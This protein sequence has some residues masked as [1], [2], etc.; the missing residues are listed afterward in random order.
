[1]S[2]WDFWIDRGGTF[3]DVI[4]RR[5]DASLYTMK[6]LS[7]DPAHYADAATE[8]IA[9]VLDHPAHTHFSDSQILS[10]RMGTTVATNALLER[11]GEPLAL[12]ATRGFRDAWRIGYQNRPDLFTRRIIL[13]E[14]LYERVVEIDERVS[15]QGEILT[16]LNIESAIP[17]LQQIFDSGLRSIAIALM[18]G[19]RWPAHE[20]KLA[21][22]ARDIGFEQVSA[23]HEVAAV[24]KLVSRGD[25]TVVDA[26]LS[27]L[28][29]R[30]IASVREF[31]DKQS[32]R[33]QLMFMQ[34]NGGLID[35]E[36]FRG[37]NSI[38]SGPAGGVVGMVHAAKSA[39]HEK[40]IGFDMGGTSTDVS[41]FDGEYRRTD[42]TEIAGVRLRAPMMAI[43]TV[44]AGGGSVLRYLDGRFQVGPDSAGANPG[45]ACY[46]HGGP[47]CITDANLMLGRIDAEFFP[48]VFGP[49]SDQSL[50]RKTVEKKFEQLTKEIPQSIS[51]HDIAEGFLRV[52]VE[53]MANAI[54]KISIR[55]G[56][57]PQ[58]FILNC[59][60]GAGGQHACQVAD[61]LDIRQVLI[62]P[63]GG[64]LSAWGIGQADVTSIYQQ[65]ALLDLTSENIAAAEAML[66]DLE[67]QAKNELFAHGNTTRSLVVHKR[68][69]LRYPGSDTTLSVHW[70]S[71]EKM[72]A[73][74][75]QLHQQ[76]FG[77][78]QSDSLLVIDRLEAEATACEPQR[79]AQLQSIISEVSP[80]PIGTRSAWFGGQKIKA[81]WYQR[82]DL[83]PGAQ[84]DG[85]ALIAESTGT[86]VLQP[87]WSLAVA[88]DGQLELKRST[89]QRRDFATGTTADPVTLEVFNNLFMHIAEEIGVVLENTAY[90]VNIKER[91]DFSC[92]LFDTEGLLIA[93]APHM[94]VH[95]GSMGDSVRTVMSENAGS[96]RLGDVYALNAPYN[97]GT[98]LPD[99]TVVTP[100]F[101]EQSPVPVF[102]VASRAHHADIGGT[103]PGSMPPDSTHID[104]EGILFDNFLLVRDGKLREADLRRALADSQYPARNPDQNIEDLKAQIA[105]NEKG[106][107][108]LLRVVDH[109][110]FDVVTAYMQHVQDNAEA[111]VR[112]VL[113][114]LEDGHFVYPLD[115]GLQ[116]EVDIKVDRETRSARIDFSGTSAQSDDNFNAPTSVCTAAVLYVFRTLVDTNIP[117][118]AGCL[119]PLNIDIPDDCILKPRYPAAVVAGNVETSQCI[120]DALYGALGTQA[121]AQGTMNNFTFGDHEYQYYETI[122]GGSGAGPGYN[123]TDA[124]HTHMTNSRLTDPE[125]LEWRFPV[126]VKSFAIR[127]ESGGDGK[128]CGGNGVTREIEFRRPMTASILSNHRLVA[129][130]G[131]ADGDSAAC[132]INTIIKADGSEQKLAATASANVDTGDVFVISTPGGGGYGKK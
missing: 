62:H 116:I 23:S 64:V 65:T 122:C 39:G 67:T 88:A 74:F 69:H 1:M 77:F 14:M 91:L 93:N 82:D 84:I 71:A 43:H 118:N 72:A 24:M 6:L 21:T 78:T 5:P 70:D 121:A 56:Y 123:G 97:G 107:N 26:Y 87:G 52:A 22:I 108:E 131:M 99:V 114:Q 45:P 98:H 129:P 90:S 53:K 101:I 57:D 112:D 19:Y 58:E 16:A 46:G 120:V 12:V 55:R 17:V 132:G 11:K 49:G 96:I 125:V 83:Q 80:T 66:A 104:Q 68:A 34:S 102:Y 111:C 38:L 92:A 32:P 44:A 29:H 106:V 51:A 42:E 61:H 130:F 103:T 73:A 86:T 105:A 27:P 59:F 128:W 127:P 124:I 54:K 94:P 48:R 113:G 13:P 28:L 76:R 110:G 60:G 117:L 4:A 115:S 35:A 50:D 75:E 36:S 41:L 40:V 85:P 10:V 31:L 119:K 89:E 25:T 20:K 18:H 7:D 2:G 3:T 126:L 109:Y 9:R 63:L 47:L 15:A 95:L 33:A 8:G 100:V 30:Y 79:Q 37:H 81:P